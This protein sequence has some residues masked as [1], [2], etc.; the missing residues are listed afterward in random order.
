M[1]T[2]YTDKSMVLRII[3]FYFTPIEIFGYALEYGI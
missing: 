2:F 3:I 1:Q